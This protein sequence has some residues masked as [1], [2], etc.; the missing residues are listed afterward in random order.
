[1]AV[2]QMGG[3]HLRDAE[4]AARSHGLGKSLLAPISMTMRS[5]LIV[6]IVFGAQPSAAGGF[7]SGLQHLAD[8]QSFELLGGCRRFFRAC[9]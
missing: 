8:H 1:M 9:L 7:A 6:L 5:G 4:S 2:L 3:D